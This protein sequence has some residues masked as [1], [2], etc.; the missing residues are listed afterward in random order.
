MIS[1]LPSMLHTFTIDLEG[2]DTRKRFQG[3][4]TYKRPNIRTQAEIAKT[5][6]FLNGGIAG[7]DEDT[8]LLHTIIA[9]LK[10]TIIESPDWWK[11]EDFGYELYDINIVFDIYKKVRKFED[12]WIAKV[13]ADNSKPEISIENKNT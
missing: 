4:F 13:W 10:H 11:K 5:T 12:E 2:S 6:A 1:S 3:T 7:V 9:T 8:L